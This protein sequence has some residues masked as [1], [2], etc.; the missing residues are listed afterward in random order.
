MSLEVEKNA[1][2]ASKGHEAG[3]LAGSKRLVSVDALRGFDMFWITGGGALIIA[4]TQM[5]PKSSV[6]EAVCA[7]MRH[8]RWEG[9]TFEDL[10]FPLFVFI[11]GIS[12]VF[13]LDKAIERDGIKAALIRICRRGALLFLLGIFQNG[14]LSTPWHDI[15]IWGVLQ[16]IGLAYV[17]TGVLYCLLRKRVWSLAAVCVGLLVGYWA[18]M[19][20]VPIRDITL[21]NRELAFL[22]QKTGDTNAAALFQKCRTYSFAYA[23]DRSARAAAE[24]LF[25]ATTNR[26]AGVYDMGQNVA[27]HFDFQYRLGM[28]FDT[29]F[30]PE[31]F[32]GVFPTIATCM[33]GLF[34]GLLLRSPS[35]KDWHKVVILLLAGAVMLGLGVWWGHYFPVVK[36]IWTSSFVLVAGGYSAMLMGLFYLVVDVWQWRLWCQPFVWVGANA[37]TIYLMQHIVSFR[38]VAKKLVGGDVAQFLDNHV[39]N[40]CGAFVVSLVAVVLTFWFLRFLYERK[41][42]LRV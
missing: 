26:V 15:R 28:Q 12:T 6:M 36:K 31:G 4:L 27:N 2:S 5:F 7:Q 14:G 24:K 3:G 16:R 37:I 39:A 19:T 41:I 32:L 35:C 22:A 40:G 1:M 21:T 42:F 8:A 33:L 13:S 17:G 29:Y 9:F 20:F 25:Y 18:V 11:V 30:D 38:D 10:I 23:N 34:V